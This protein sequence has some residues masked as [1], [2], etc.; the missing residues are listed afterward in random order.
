MG[1]GAALTVLL[2]VMATDACGGNGSA[3]DGR[4]RATSTSVPRVSVRITAPQEEASVR[5][6]VAVH[7]LVSPTN[8]TVDVNGKAAHVRAGRF[9]AVV[10]LR[11]G[12]H[13]VQATAAAAGVSDQASVAVK[14]LPT[15]AEKQVAAR[16]K[17]AKSRRQQAAKRTPSGSSEPDG[18]FVMPNEVG[19]N[20]QEAQDDVQRASGDPLFVSHSRDATGA[21]RFQILDRDW[22]VCGQNVPAGQRVSGI[23]HIVFST[24]KDYEDCP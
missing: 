8:A 7:G 21:G 22:K 10:V 12:D 18:S 16:K 19:A 6:R 20:L 13:E 5:P 24:V 1:K 23:A 17:A 4:P 2:I 3:G 11:K 15:A 9:N 14:R